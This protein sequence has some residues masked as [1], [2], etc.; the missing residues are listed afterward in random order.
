MFSK[1]CN[2]IAKCNSPGVSTAACVIR[3]LIKLC[4]LYLF[5]NRFSTSTSGRVYSGP[6]FRSDRFS[7][8]C[9]S[10]R[11]VVKYNTNVDYVIP[12]LRSLSNIRLLKG[13]RVF[14]AKAIFLWAKIE[15]V[16]IYN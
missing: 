16:K 9:F 13:L 15:T 3:N 12:I 6:D 11:L 8:I 2:K 14:R 5:V 10:R 4:I 7:E 1:I